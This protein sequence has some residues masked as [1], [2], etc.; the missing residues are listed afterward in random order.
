MSTPVSVESAD[1]RALAAVVDHHAMLR[2]GLDE[3]VRALRTAVATADEHQQRCT[4]LVGFV[5]DRVLPHAAAEE[6]TLYPAAAASAPLLVEGMKAEHRALTDRARALAHAESAVDALAAAEGFAAVFAVHVD[7][8]NELLLPALIRDPDS[9]LAALLQAMHE[10]LEVP[11]HPDDRAEEPPEQ[12]DVRRLPHGAGRHETI[13]AR[14]DTLRA[15]GQL[16]IVNDHDPR[17]L[18]FQLDAAWPE[19]FTWNYL[20]NGP[21]VWRVAIARL[22]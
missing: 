2:R 17:P 12:L 11:Q 20:E 5:G 8:E 16:V 10:Q 1:Q 3:R 18:H 22:V 6:A 9:S 19:V 21:Q 7:K 14:L 4:D 15:G 13:L